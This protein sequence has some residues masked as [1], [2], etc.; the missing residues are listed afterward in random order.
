MKHIL[1]LFLIAA[2]AAAF[3]YFFKNMA[4]AKHVADKAND[5]LSL[6]FRGE[7]DS[8]ELN[9]GSSLEIY[10][11]KH[12]SLAI[13]VAG[14]WIY[15]DPVTTAALPET[16][17]S[18]LPKA[19]Y[20]LFTHNHYDHFDTVAVSQLRVENTRIF[21]NETTINE[22]GFGTSLFNGDAATTAEGWIIEAVPA[23]NNSIEKLQFH[24]KGRDNGY[25]LTI[26]GLRIYIA[27]D[28]EVIPELSMLKD[29]DVA[30]LPCNL[31][32]TMSPEQC[33][34][35][36]KIVAPKILFPYHYGCADGPSDLQSLINNLDGSGIEVRIRQYA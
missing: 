32:Y 11:I 9:D 26:A 12:G 33:A 8:F 29:I 25:V 18:V 36:A 14:K 2:G 34:S 31:P 15:V 13:N 27:G 6:L 23:Y 35:A 20:I 4:S 1:L 22:L 19:D 7:K 30:F 5:D 21:A 17:F 16:D 3:F 10:S 28:T 24:P